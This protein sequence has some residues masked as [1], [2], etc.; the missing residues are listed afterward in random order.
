MK[1]YMSTLI[2]LF[3]S[4]SISLGQEVTKTQII[5]SRNYYYGTGISHDVN[6][7]K[8]H[9]LK[10]LTGQIAV[11]VASSYEKKVQETG[12][13]LNVTVESIVKTHSAA[14]L[15]NVQ[16]IKQPAGD[17]RI[18]VFCY[19][20]KSKVQE[21]FEERKKLIAEMVKTAKISLARQNVGN[22]LKLYYFAA[23][24]L[25]SLPD[26]NVV[27][28]DVSYT[29]EIPQSIN[30][31][32]MNTNLEF[33]E[34][35]YTGE[36]E[37]E[38][39]LKTTYNG[40]PATLLDFTFW[41][42]SNQ[43]SVQA[44][45]GLATFHLLG[46]SV[47]FDKLKLNIKYAYYECRNEYDIVASLWPLVNKPEYKSQ[48]DVRLKKTKKIVK[49]RK[50]RRYRVN[51]KYD[52]SENPPAKKIAE[53][54]ITF[55]KVLDSGKLASQVNYYA[56]DN[57]LR[58]KVSDYIK[59][60]NAKPLDEDIQASLNKTRN[61]WELRRIRMRHTYPSIH[62]ET[63]EY[64]VLDFSKGG[65]LLDLN[66]SIADVL[67]QEFVSEVS[68]GD[69]WGNR[70]EIIKF[71]EKYRTAYQTR[72]INTVGM[73]F[74]EEALIIIGRIIK[75]KK[76]PDDMIKYEK[77]GN[78]PDVEYLQLTKS[79]YLNR[80]EQIFKSQNDIFLE[81][82]SFNIIQKNNCPNVYGVEMR[83]G[84]TSTTY[85]DEGYLFLL[86]DFNEQ[87]PLIYVR[88]WQPNAW[89][90]DELIRTANFRIYK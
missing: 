74:A 38:V 33:K 64:V 43:V 3:M 15:K 47:K 40:K 68:F 62:K 67:Y 59:F 48:K 4:F 80:Q 76:I 41:D 6:E 71:L 30:E 57:F 45:D 78:Q 52:E 66:L 27:Y 22:A 26:Q 1:K 56:Q 28:K 34:D 21:I 70:Q 35:R 69:D 75:T 13:D 49:P 63:T 61:G 87:D 82:G 88:A 23:I 53:S 42:G 32:V 2:L 17:G 89:S 11:R 18:E 10:E 86:I 65:V 58:N 60:N 14:T 24:L 54:A 85:A 44:R 72:D 73:M 5:N 90:E 9:A 55:L 51:L 37:R 16:T 81:F 50:E 29:T 7:A 12:D 77:L 31:I 79:K 84:Y 19:L 39:T 8:D 83:Q 46:A 36:K 25:N 20:E